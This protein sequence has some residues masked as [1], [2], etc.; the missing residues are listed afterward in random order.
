VQ[1]SNA[2]PLS[3]AF[4]MDTIM[5]LIQ[6]K[7]LSEQ[8]RPFISE[9]LEVGN[10]KGVHEDVQADQLRAQKEIDKII[11]GGPHDIMEYD[12]D[13]E[14]IIVKLR[15]LKSEYDNL[16]QDQRARIIAAIKEHE[17]QLAMKAP[18]MP[19]GP[20]P[21]G[22]GGEMPPEAAMPMGGMAQ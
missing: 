11:E 20:M 9:S 14:H 12:D 13:N 22:G 1:N 16:S 2:N 7:I 3:K 19:E 6:Y 21:P 18:P 4:K 10:L 8:D 17:E 15:Y 5:Q